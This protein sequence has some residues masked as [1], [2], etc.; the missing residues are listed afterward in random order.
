MD[1]DE[2]CVA[3]AVA[4]LGSFFKGDEFVGG[5][6]EDDAQACGFEQWFGLERGVEGEVFFVEAEERAGAAIVSAMAGVEDDGIEEACPGAI[7]L[8]CATGKE[9]EW[10]KEC[11]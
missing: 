10:R 1:A 4:Q 9:E 11:G 6:S 2:D 5:A 3:F 7:I 8:D